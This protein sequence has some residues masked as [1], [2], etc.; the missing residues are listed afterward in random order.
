[1]KFLLGIC[2]W[3]LPLKNLKVN[4]A[5]GFR[6]HPITGRYIMHDGVDLKARHDTVYA[7]LDGFVSYAGYG[8]GLG[9]HIRL[10]HGPIKSIYGHLSEVFVAQN[11]T[12]MAGEPIGITG[13]TG[14]V[15]GEHLHFG[16]LY[17]DKYINPL[18]F[19]YELLNQKDNEQKLQSASGTAF[20]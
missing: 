6:V 19:L 14:R 1:M 5:F 15:T 13:A 18:Q 3:C 7:I 12:V 17:R 2:L 8:D 10:A 4:S 20:R 16:I 11:E 9:I